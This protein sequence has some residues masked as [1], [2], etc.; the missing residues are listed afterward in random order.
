MSVSN[1]GKISLSV[2]NILTFFQIFNMAGDAI[3]DL[4]ICEISLTDSVSKTQTHYR[5]KC[6]QNWSTVV[7][8]L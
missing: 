6:R 8:T 5:A 3:L 2:A 1:F 7:A 4:Q